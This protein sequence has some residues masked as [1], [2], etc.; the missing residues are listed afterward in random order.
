MLT[1]MA[2]IVDFNGGQIWLQ[3]AQFHPKRLTF[4]AKLIEQNE[5]FLLPVQVSPSDVVWA[6]SESMV[7]LVVAHQSLA[8]G[9]PRT[10]I[11]RA[12]TEAVS[13]SSSHLATYSDACTFCGKVIE[14]NER[15]RLQVVAEKTTV[16]RAR[17]QSVVNLVCLPKIGGPHQSQRT[18]QLA[19]AANTLQLDQPGCSGSVWSSR[20]GD[21]YYRWTHQKQTC[22]GES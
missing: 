13:A 14:A 10:K 9:A 12:P 21:F 22:C 18:T 2:G 4:C 6:R 11:W 3:L 19:Q 1:S 5:R 16:V 7:V 8:A 17:S 15:F 20:R